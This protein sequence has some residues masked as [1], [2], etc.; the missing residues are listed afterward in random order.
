MSSERIIPEKITIPGSSGKWLSGV[1][2]WLEGGN[3]GLGPTLRSITVARP[4]QNI[5]SASIYDLCQVDHST[6]VRDQLNAHETHAM[7]TAVKSVHVASTISRDSLGSVGVDRGTHAD[8]NVIE[9]VHDITE[10][11]TQDVAWTYMD[12][13]GTDRFS[14]NHPHTE[15][16]QQ[17]MGMQ[18]NSL[19]RGMK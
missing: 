9:G 8:T 14:G 4:A 3:S 17:A 19:Q 11:L 16:H 5:N 2:K 12:E 15:V 6:H 18:Q 1:F 10:V 7:G 13:H